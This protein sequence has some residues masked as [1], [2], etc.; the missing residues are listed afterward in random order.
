M[1]DLNVNFQ[2][3]SEL[4]GVY[5]Q[6]SFSE[7]KQKFESLANS[8]HPDSITG[9][10]TRYQELTEAYNYFLKKLKT[11]KEKAHLQDQ[12][13]GP[14]SQSTS[15]SNALGEKRMYSNLFESMSK[16]PSKIFKPEHLK[17]SEIDEDQQKADQ[18]KLKNISHF[19]YY[20]P[21]K[22]A[23]KK[24]IPA[25]KILKATTEHLN[26]VVKLDWLQL[27]KSWN[28]GLNYQKKIS[29][30]YNE[31]CDCEQV[32][33]RCRGASIQNSINCSI[34][35]NQGVVNYCECCKGTGIK[36]IPDKYTI[37]LRKNE[38]PS[39]TIVV[40]NKGDVMQN[41]FRGPFILKINL[42][43]KDLKRKNH[44]F[45]Y[46]RYINPE[47]IVNNDEIKIELTPSKGIILKLSSIK[48]LPYYINATQVY[49]GVNINQQKISFYI[50]IGLVLE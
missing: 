40:P 42:K 12:P 13:T 39:E 23:L 7:L 27:L 26:C 35:N 44:Q 30:L 25:D 17:K 8:L 15:E 2:K 38:E 3:Y 45:M 47:Q 5:G 29:Y 46:Y 33:S 4:L 16:Y 41:G 1:L 37:V 24:E 50:R 22:R 32:C 49:S 20:D 21:T 11:Q 19:N 9:D 6:Y 48:K 43:S 14:G 28:E 36:S 34:C 18:K 10:S 31:A